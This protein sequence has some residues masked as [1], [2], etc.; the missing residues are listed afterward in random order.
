MLAI[1]ANVINW[2]TSL[3]LLMAS[4]FNAHSSFYTAQSAPTTVVW[5]AWTN[6][7]SQIALVF[8]LI[9]KYWLM[10]A[11]TVALSC[12]EAAV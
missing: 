4:V 8:V 12:L 3:I 7:L 9:R 5:S 2:T 11:V 10:G 1:Y 6:L